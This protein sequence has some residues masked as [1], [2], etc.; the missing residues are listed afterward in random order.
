MIASNKVKPFV[1]QELLNVIKT[2]PGQ[3]PKRVR[4]LPNVDCVAK[5]VTLAILSQTMKNFSKA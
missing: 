4:G 1:G 5:D 2:Q 3:S